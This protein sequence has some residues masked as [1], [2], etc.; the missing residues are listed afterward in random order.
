M[1]LSELVRSKEGIMRI[2]SGAL[3]LVLLLGTVPVVWAQADPAKE[4]AE[5]A[6]K[7]AAAADRGDVDAWLADLADNVIFTVARAGF[8]I[9]GKEAVRAFI[10][11]LWKNY[12][13]RQELTQQVTRRI[14]QDGN[15]FIVNSY[16]D[17]IFM[18]KNGRMSTMMQRN[19]LTWVKT[20]GR[21]LIVDV[22]NS[23]MPGAPYTP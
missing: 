19:S 11:N 6:R 13:T 4:V 23:G 15:V 1:K 22:H 8:R 17:Q 3:A 16:T 14:F 9:E 2:L 12:P 10:T 20:G 18:D 7:R 21:W 5:I